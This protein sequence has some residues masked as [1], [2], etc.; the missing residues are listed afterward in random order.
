MIVL[1]RCQNRAIICKKG[2][3]RIFILSVRCI[4]Y[5]YE[6]QRRTQYRP[7]L[8]PEIYMS[9]F[10]VFFHQL[11][12][13]VLPFKRKSLTVGEQFLWHDKLEAFWARFRDWLYRMPYS[14]IKMCRYFFSILL[15]FARIV[16][17]KSISAFN[18]DFFRKP[19]FSA[20]SKSNF[21]Q[22]NSSFLTGYFFRK[23]YSTMITIRLDGSF[24]GSPYHLFWRV[25][26]FWHFEECLE[27]ILLEC[28]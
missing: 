16:S 22:K 10:W 12:K 4:I 26:L 18:F 3:L 27:K 11:V 17:D 9:N 24:W 23:F 28:I 6:E 14:N 25:A 2:S 5:V 8:Y 20:F 21:F 19:F 1:V 7:L 13:N 15:I